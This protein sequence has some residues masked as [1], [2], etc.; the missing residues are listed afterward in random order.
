M[1]SHAL[2]TVPH[3]RDCPALASNGDHDWLHCEKYVGVEARR[4]T[5]IKVRE[6]FEG[7]QPVVYDPTTHSELAPDERYDVY[8]TCSTDALSDETLEQLDEWLECRYCSAEVRG[9]RLMEVEWQE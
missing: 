5:S 6:P 4:V 3:P 1:R 2:G 8:P 9:E 7:A